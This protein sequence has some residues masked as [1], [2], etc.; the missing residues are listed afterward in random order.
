VC[1]WFFSVDCPRAEELYE[2]NN[3]L[4]KDKDGNPI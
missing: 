3:E 1:D 2:N 4:Y